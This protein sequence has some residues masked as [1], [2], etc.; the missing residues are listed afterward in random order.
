M[1]PSE[2]YSVEDRSRIESGERLRAIADHVP[3]LLAY[4]DTEYRYQFANEAYRTWFG[5]D[6]A[7]MIGRTVEE[8]FGSGVAERARV[9]MQ[10][11]IAGETVS[12]QTETRVRGDNR[13]V[14]GNYAPDFD[15]EGR[16]CGFY[17]TVTDAT[18]RARAARALQEL[19]AVQV[20][21]LDSANLAI[22]ATD[23]QGVIWTFNSTAE[24][25]LG[26]RA[27]EIIGRAGL[28]QLLDRGELA[29]RERELA[30]HSGSAIETLLDWV[31]AAIGNAGRTHDE[32]EWTF[33][34]KD[35]SRFPVALSL[36]VLRDAAGEPAGMLGV[37][38]DITVEKA[39]EAERSR[40]R[41]A[42]E[43]ASRT[44]SQFLAHMSHEVRTPLHGI[45]GV[46]GMLLE[47]P[48][49]PSQR[50][51]AE[52][53]HAS[54]QAL[55]AVLNRVL[56][57]SKVEA[58]KLV[59]ESRDFSPV[60]VVRD[61]VRLHAVRAEAKGVS[62][63]WEADPAVPE[64]VCGDGDRLRQVV[65]NLVGNAVKFSSH[66]TVRIRVEAMND[67]GVEVPAAA[68]RIGLRFSVR[69]EGIGIPIE[70]LD[71]IF[72]PFTQADETMAR[73][74]GGTGLGLAIA[75]QLVELMGG[76]IGADST[77]DAGSTF[78]FTA[79]FGQAHGRSQ[80]SPVQ[81]M[82]DAPAAMTMNARKFRV[83]LVDDGETNRMVAEH[84]LRQLGCD[85][86]GVDSG[87]AAIEF[88]RRENFDLIFMDCQM[89]D[90]DGFAA[91]A[92]IRCHEAQTGRRTRIVALTALV[93]EGER[94]RCLAAGMD[95]YLEKPF[96]P[97]QLAVIVSAA[98]AGQMVESFP[99][100]PV[101]AA[102]LEELRGEPQT[103][104]EPLLVRLIR[105][106][107]REAPE[108]LRAMVAESG[109]GGDAAALEIAAH[110]LKGA[111]R[112]FGAARLQDLCQVVEE[113]C[114]EKEERFVPWVLP[115]IEKELSA[116][117]E[118]LQ[119]AI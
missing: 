11:A 56:D 23:E 88:V 84:Q 31:L 44:K 82:P 1:T 28:G 37:A 35:G 38:R 30:P 70:A 74:F 54:A 17:L 79:V 10:R 43:Q 15:A 103:S 87:R 94:E 3:A 69:D 48:L 118:A 98:G 21:I 85:C 22:V 7:G 93:S 117:L 92:E 52:T 109:E 19:T 101:N 50:P 9:R 59:L 33:V 62:I 40:A 6:P 83:L 29:A 104:R 41:E 57:F 96:Q 58:G 99:A 16:V 55:L 86:T 4:L 113:L 20:A 51:L 102:A 115:A 119:R 25:W 112:N 77:P 107:E 100:A 73:R 67:S 26:Y 95:E 34:R 24:R 60:A 47:T 80:V 14:D 75:R 81:A 13:P 65:H 89:P 72:E 36:N 46:T 108:S 111:S 18:E 49:D 91:T 45:I 64:Y 76:E 27:E 78:W 8:V 106:Y 61:V 5:I 42:A 66:G 105:I 32:R 53:V 63:D 90:V 110:K 114:H 2:L 71:R 12:F 39:A 116:V 97:T 68:S